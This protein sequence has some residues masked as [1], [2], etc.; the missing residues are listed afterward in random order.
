V[1]LTAM[2]SKRFIERRLAVITKGARPNRLPD[3][4]FVTTRRPLCCSAGPGDRRTD[5]NRSVVLTVYPIVLNQSGS[6]V[7]TSSLIVKTCAD[8]MD[9]NASD[10]TIDLNGMEIVGG[11]TNCGSGVG[12][13][14]QGG[15]L[16]TINDGKVAQFGS[17]G[18]VLG[19]S[20]TVHDVR[21]F[22]NGFHGIVCADG[23]QIFNNVVNNNKSFGIDV[24][25]SGRVSNNVVQFNGN[26]GIRVGDFSLVEENTA[27]NN[28]SGIV[29][30]SDLTG[31]SLV[32]DNI[33]CANAQFGLECLSSNTGYSSNQFSCVAGVDENG[34]GSV[35][36]ECHDLGH[37]L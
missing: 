15:H 16:I 34:Q 20:S 27:D 9:I 35:F 30:D 21:V 5:R 3:S 22:A 10:V 7:L 12:I 36:T 26:A 14:A 17:S 13:N 11:G 25:G 2:P 19:H 28:L 1:R 37:N 32:L 29:C 18:I 24:P 6:Y 33:A 23:C 8:A 31:G 4:R